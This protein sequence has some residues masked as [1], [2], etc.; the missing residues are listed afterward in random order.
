MYPKSAPFTAREREESFKFANG[1][2]VKL[3]GMIDRQIDDDNDEEGRSNVMM[4]TTTMVNRGWQS[5]RYDTRR[6]VRTS[7]DRPEVRCHGRWTP[8]M[9]TDNLFHVSSLLQPSNKRN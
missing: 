9:S 8:S 7:A 4:P 3:K 6:P 2:D 5:A 1:I